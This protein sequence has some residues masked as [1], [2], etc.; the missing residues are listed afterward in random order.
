MSKDQ[1]KVIDLLTI[2]I[3]K[4]KSLNHMKTKRKTQLQQIEIRVTT[5]LKKNPAD[6]TITLYKATERF[7]AIINCPT[8][9][10]IIDIRKLLLPVLTRKKYDEITLTHN[11]SGFILPTERYKHI[12]N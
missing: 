1:M 8:D 2:L 3:K 4:I 6:L 5:M 7:M 10:D 9:N 11:L 12:Y